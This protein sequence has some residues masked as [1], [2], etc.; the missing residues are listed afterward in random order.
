MEK[1]TGIKDKYDNRIY[2]GDVVKCKL[3]DLAVKAVVRFSKHHKTFG[4]SLFS[5][6]PLKEFKDLE[7]IKDKDIIKLS[8][9]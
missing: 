1:Y 2:S 4:L 3:G 7:I 6:I 8:K 9:K 5:I